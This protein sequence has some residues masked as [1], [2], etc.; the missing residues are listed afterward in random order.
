M[1]QQNEESILPASTKELD[2]LRVEEVGQ[3][4]GESELLGNEDL[5]EKLRRIHVG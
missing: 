4:E 3:N 1:D 5:V 2:T